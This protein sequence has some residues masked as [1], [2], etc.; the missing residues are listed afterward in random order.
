M[1]LLQERGPGHV[2]AH[3]YG[4]NTAVIAAQ[5]APD[6]VKSLALLEPACFDLSRGKPAVEGHIASMSPVFAVAGD[7]DVSAREF[8]IRFADAMGT[9]PPDLPEALLEERVTR[10]RTMAPP[11]STGID[12]AL[13]LPVRTLVVTGRTNRLYEEV[14][15]ALVELGAQ[16]STIHEGGHRVQDVQVIDK[17]LREFWRKK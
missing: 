12:V 1:A 13:G 9:P 11:W 7:P 8:S 4:G 15:D 6:L 17:L 16:H 3:S 14:A 10:L 2:V 5:R